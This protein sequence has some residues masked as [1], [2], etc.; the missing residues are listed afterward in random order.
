MS[1]AD[2]SEGSCAVESEVAAI[3]EGAQ[4]DDDV[5]LRTET[6]ISID[7]D[8]DDVESA[9]HSVADVAGPMPDLA[10]EKTTPP[11]VLQFHVEHP[12]EKAPSELTGLVRLA[13]I[14]H[15]MRGAGDRRPP[16]DH[17]HHILISALGA[18]VAIACLA[19]INNYATEPVQLTQLMMSFGASAVLLYGVPKSPL[20]QPRNLVGSHL[21]AAVI[22][23]SVR[24]IFEVIRWRT[25]I[26]VIWLGYPISMSLSLAVMQ[27]TVTTHPPGLLFDTVG[28]VGWAVLMH[29][30][31]GAT[32]LIAASQPTFTQIGYG[33]LFLL[34]PV[35]SGCAIMLVV[36]LFVNNI[37]RTRHY[38]TFW[39]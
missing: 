24:N 29:A 4:A 10:V 23:I 2:A 25:G 12:T 37:P 1:L 8:A 20:S 7:L 15:K 6:H 13:N 18:F 14:F 26:D 32:A 28:L 27:L 30:T 31:G 33:Y 5:D 22:G 21:I 38:P 3:A 17:V 36:A 19:A 16:R 11:G 34:I 35:L 9:R 39:F